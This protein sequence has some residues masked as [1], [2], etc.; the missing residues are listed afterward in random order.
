[1]TNAPWYVT[2]ETIHRDLRIAVAVVAID[3]WKHDVCMEGWVWREWEYK[4][5]VMV[6]KKLWELKQSVRLKYMYFVIS[7]KSISN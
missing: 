4:S 7:I 1:M 5:G 6:T 2:N 3:E